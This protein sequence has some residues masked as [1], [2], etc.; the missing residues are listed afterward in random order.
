MSDLHE[1]LARHGS[2]AVAG[3]QT[4]LAS[5]QTS[6]AL[7]ARVRTGRRRRA[8]GGA[9]VVAG[10][11]VLGVGLWAALPG[12]PRAWQPA[13]GRDSSYVYVLASDADFPV[14]EP[15]VLVDG[16]DATELQCG[17]TVSLTPGVTVHD[18]AAFEGAIELKALLGE[19]EVS[20]GGGFD[21]ASVEMWTAMWGG[22]GLDWQVGSY[23]LDGDTVVAAVNGIR[24]V[25]NVADAGM[26]WG[27]TTMAALSPE[28]CGSGDEPSFP[29]YPELAPAAEPGMVPVLVAQ[30]MEGGR[31]LATIVVD[32][33]VPTAIPGAEDLTE[34]SGGVFQE[35]VLPRPEAACDALGDMRASGS[36]AQGDYVSLTNLGDAVLPFS[37]VLGGSTIA[38]GPLP[39]WIEQ[40]N[41]WI[42]I[43]S[44]EGAQS[45]PLH[46]IENGDGRAEL[47]LGGDG[48]PDPLLAEGCETPDAIQGDGAVF[49]VVDGVSYADLEPLGASG[50]FD[51]DPLV[52]DTGLQ[53]W[54]YL[55]SASQ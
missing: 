29:E 12:E 26:M 24:T 48:A 54:I 25:V 42:V 15:T 38:R 44:G 49:L 33:R 30:A 4:R 27:G 1:R 18:E 34:P 43:D 11:A 17:D 50:L 55:G 8:M 6:D 3:S 2:D 53:T 7:V 22:L 41:A 14:T 31:L 40:Q 51:V 28:Q 23:L 32:P 10:V 52:D 21:Y 16:D 9:G 36:P 39:D 47:Q 35:F 37:Q 45:I 5:Q 13:D 46:W 20:Q 19:R